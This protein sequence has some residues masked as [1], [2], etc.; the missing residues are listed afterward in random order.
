MV[1]V[2]VLQSQF[3]TAKG[4]PHDREPLS[5]GGHLEAS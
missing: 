5:F 1:F 2:V 4:A 3:A